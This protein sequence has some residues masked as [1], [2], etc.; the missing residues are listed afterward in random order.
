MKSRTPATT[1]WLLLTNIMLALSVC[2]CAYSTFIFF[3]PQ[4]NLN[5]LPPPTRTPRPLPTVPENVT[6]LTEVPVTAP[7]E[8][9]IT[10]G[11][12]AEVIVPITETS[13]SNVSTST[14]TPTPLGA[15]PTVNAG[16]SA[17]PTLTLTP[18]PPPSTSL[19]TEGYPGGGGSGNPPLPTG[20]P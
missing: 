5:L 19:P 16:A 10:L 6:S 4:S 14:A 15:S 8:P 11:P 13:P 17:T 7:P 20:Y 9:S 18:I 12:T 3:N 2:M 1:L